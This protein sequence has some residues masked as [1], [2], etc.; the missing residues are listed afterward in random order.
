MPCIRVSIEALSALRLDGDSFVVPAS[1]VGVLLRC[2]GINSSWRRLVGLG[3][4]TRCGRRAI[5][6]VSLSSRPPSGGGCAV[7]AFQLPRLEHNTQKHT[8]ILQ[9][10]GVFSMLLSSQ[11]LI[12]RNI[13]HILQQSRSAFI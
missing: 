13:L 11:Y 2:P 8:L 1:L 3:Q 4:Q 7:V 9:G 10:Y 6:G 5:L 12:L